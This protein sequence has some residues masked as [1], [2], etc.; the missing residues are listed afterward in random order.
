MK[1]QMLGCSHRRSSVAIRERLAF[2]PAQAEAALDD[3]RSR[4]PET[5]AVLLS[6][7]NRI[8]VY[9]AA[10]EP[11]RGP[12]HQELAEFLARFHGLNVYEI[13]DELFERTGEDAVRH[14]F[15]VAASLDSMVLGEPQIVRQVKQAYDLALDRRTTGPLTNQIF[16]AAL[17]VAKRVASETSI[18]EKRISIPSVAVADFAKQIFERFDDK[19]VLVIGAG[20][21]GEET[22]RYLQDEGARDVTVVNRNFE[23]ARG[24]AE[25]WRGRALPWEQLGEALAAADLVIGTTGASEPIVTLADYRRIEA[26][27]YQRDWFVLDLAIPRDFDPAIGDCLGVYLYS[28]DDLQAAC[29][30]NRQERD[31]ELPKAL[32]IIEEETARFMGELNHYATGPIIKRLRQGWQQPKDDELGRLFGRLPGLSDRDRQEIR[33]SFDRLINKLLHPP[34]ESLRDESKHGVPHGLLDAIK[35][36]F[37]LK[38]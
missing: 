12:T 26:A 29:E 36:L 20:E 27:R 11:G 33:Q 22:L 9:T 5:E 15:T 37:Q 4:F 35:R 28:I 34:L 6:T 16:Q 3:L 18:N 24:L 31:R 10:E 38:D 23:R 21:M 19:R 25:R 30:R 14:L 2:S 1:L 7:C 17:R 13:F 8:E 32:K